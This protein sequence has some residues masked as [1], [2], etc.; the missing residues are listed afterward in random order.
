[1][2]TIPANPSPIPI[3]GAI[4]EML[5][6]RDIEG[7]LAGGWGPMPTIFWAR[8]SW[9]WTQNA[10]VPIRTPGELTFPNLAAHRDAWIVQG[11]EFAR[12]EFQEDPRERLYAAITLTSIKLQGDSALAHKSSTVRS[13]RAAPAWNCAR[14]SLFFCRRQPDGW[15]IAGFVGYLPVALAR[16]PVSASIHRLD[17]TL[18]NVQGP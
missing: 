4:W 10:P 13:S 14:Q 12:T 1:M 2:E 16:G 11:R 18:R 9:G 5:V 17:S 6:P 15:K 7:F 8:G 3:A